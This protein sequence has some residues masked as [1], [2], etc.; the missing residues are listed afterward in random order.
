MLSLKSFIVSAVV[1]VS[2]NSLSDIIIIV[3][4]VT[5]TVR[6]LV[7][8]YKYKYTLVPSPHPS[9]EARA[10]NFKFQQIVLSYIRN[11]VYK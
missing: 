8:N 1:A 6:N 5:I 7:T 9:V 10:S 4:N 11:G 3:T 2:F